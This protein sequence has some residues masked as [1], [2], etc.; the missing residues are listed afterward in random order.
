VPL[1]SID[2]SRGSVQTRQLYL[3]INKYG[4]NVLGRAK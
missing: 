3:I 2:V 1:S 4:E